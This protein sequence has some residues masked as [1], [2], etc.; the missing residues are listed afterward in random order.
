[1]NNNHS[2]FYYIFVYPFVWIYQQMEYIFYVYIYPIYTGKAVA[3]GW[4]PKLVREQNPNNWN[5]SIPLEI[6]YKEYLR[7]PN[8]ILSDLGVERTK[9]GHLRRLYS[10]QMYYADPEK[11]S[12]LG[13]KAKKYYL[14]NELFMKE[15][16]KRKMTLDPFAKENSFY[17][18]D[19]KVKD[20]DILS[21][22]IQ[23]TVKLFSSFY[24]DI[25]ELLLS[26]IFFLVFF[27]CYFIFYHLYKLNLKLER[28][29][30]ILNENGLSLFK[31]KEQITAKYMDEAWKESTKITKNFYLGI[32]L[33]FCAYEGSL[34][35]FELL[36]IMAGFY[37]LKLFYSFFSYYI[38]GFYDLNSDFFTYCFCYL[39]FFL[40]I[41]Y[42]I[43]YKRE[44]KKAIH[45][46]VEID[47]YFSY[48]LTHYFRTLCWLNVYKL[49]TDAPLY[50]YVFIYTF[51]M[52]WI[53]L[54]CDSCDYF[55]GWNQEYRIDIYNRQ[56][57]MHFWWPRI[58][59]NQT[60]HH[61][62]I[63]IMKPIH[64]RLVYIMLFFYLP[65]LAVYL[66]FV[67]YQNKLHVYINNKFFFWNSERYTIDQIKEQW[68]TDRKRNII[69]EEE[70]NSKFGGL[71]IL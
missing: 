61:G 22:N 52:V 38:V 3:Q 17:H 13:D 16:Y 67:Y 8:E 57:N 1:M 44:K 49:V 11:A 12:F 9:A 56:T 51:S 21:Y 59:M 33:N 7:L 45:R 28:A 69:E 37:L 24:I 41:Y 64:K 66:A 27:L 19:L 58:L 54:A 42:W 55:M 20:L 6:K 2:I 36:L 30:Y 15:E 63:T 50:M 53:Y 70:R 68:R 60:W 40:S 62:I 5:P 39:F 46:W 65:V 26:I 18:N 43:K 48:F 34:I 4:N 35:S 32:E 14:E 31:S 29:E 23:G 47:Y 25:V 10:P 71:T